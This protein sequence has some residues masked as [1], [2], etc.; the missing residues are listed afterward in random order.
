MK[1]EKIELEN[2]RVFYGA[3]HLEFST[4]PERN[5]TLIRAGNGVGKTTLL[6]AIF[7]GLY[8]E[9]VGR[10]FSEE[11]NA[12]MVNLAALKEGKQRSTVSVEFE[13]NK[14]RYAV[15][16]DF[17]SVD[18]KCGPGHLLQA[19]KFV[20]GK[21]EPVQSVQT[22][23]NSILPR[24]TASKF[25]VD[26]ERLSFYG[27]E[28][29]SEKWKKEI[30]NILGSEVSDAKLSDARQQVS[31]CVD[32]CL[33][34]QH[35][36]RRYNFAFNDDYSMDFVCDGRVLRC[37]ATGE[38]VLIGLAFT[39]LLARLVSV[40]SGGAPMLLDSP[41]GSLD[42]MWREVAAEF[43][44]QMASQVIL[45]LSG[46]ECDGDTLDKL[47]PHIGAEY[48]FINEGN[49]SATRIERIT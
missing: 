20:D 15:R 44:P 2:F 49:Y 36:A 27:C 48:A 37:R 46:H 18:A 8:G 31:K 30:Q 9:F 7:W 43:I 23:I 34:V 35:A 41:F 4:D 39:A 21:M 1:L 11:P 22:F 6:N 25:F 45:L 26:G 16:R 5:I 13:S 3:Q 40:R 29:Q 32:R 17:I 28:A 19:H 33:K 10:Y 47:R 12:L 38:N 24:D 42:M 14:T